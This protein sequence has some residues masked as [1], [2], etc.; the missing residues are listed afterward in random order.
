MPKTVSHL[1]LGEVFD[2]VPR[3]YKDK[4]YFWRTVHT[5]HVS[6]SLEMKAAYVFMAYVELVRQLLGNPDTP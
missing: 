5:A 2:G 6:V 3:K 1:R 4:G